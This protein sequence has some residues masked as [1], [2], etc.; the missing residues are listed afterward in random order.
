M[1]LLLKTQGPL[2]LCHFTKSWDQTYE[3]HDIFFD[4][5]SNCLILFKEG[6]FTVW[7]QYDKYLKLGQESFTIHLAAV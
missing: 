7:D 1:D 2:N 5:F 3:D 6:V 4:S